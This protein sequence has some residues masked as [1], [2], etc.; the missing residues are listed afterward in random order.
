[1]HLSDIVRIDRDQF[2][3]FCKSFE[4]ASAP[5]K[6]PFRYSH[7]F[8]S[9]LNYRR[10]LR[11][12]FMRI[13]RNT[14]LLCTFGIGGEIQVPKLTPSQ[15][16]ARLAPWALED[17][18]KSGLTDEYIDACGCYDVETDPRIVAQWLVSSRY[19]GKRTEGKS[20]RKWKRRRVHVY[21]R[22]NVDDDLHNK[23]LN[24]G[25]WLKISYRDPERGYLER[26]TR[27]KPRKPWVNANGKSAKYLSAKG[28]KSRVYVPATGITRSDLEN[29]SLPLIITEGEKKADAAN[30]AG[31]V[32]IAIPGV[33]AWVKRSA[34]FPERKYILDDLAAA[35]V[36]N[37][38]VYL[39][40][41]SDLRDNLSVRH[42]LDTFADLLWGRHFADVRIVF[43]PNG[44]NGGKVG[45]DDYLTQCR[46]AGH[47]PSVS[48]NSLLSDAKCPGRHRPGRELATIG[49]CAKCFELDGPCES[50]LRRYLFP[51]W[52]GAWD[53]E[54][55]SFTNLPA[56][57]SLRCC[58]MIRKRCQH[59]E[60]RNWFR[61]LLIDCGQW[62]CENCKAKRTYNE[63]VHVERLWFLPGSYPRLDSDP[64]TPAEIHYAAV[65]DGA[66][67]KRVRNRLSKDKQNYTAIIDRFG[68]VH[69][70]SDQEFS[71]GDV[72]SRPLSPRE[73]FDDW[74]RRV[75]ALGSW[76]PGKHAIRRS[77]SWKMPEDHEKTNEWECVKDCDETQDEYDWLDHA[78]KLGGSGASSCGSGID[79][80]EKFGRLRRVHSLWNFRVPEIAVAEFLSLI[81]SPEIRPADDS[82][83]PPD[84]VRTVSPAEQFR[85][86]QPH[87]LL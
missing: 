81:V 33:W 82:G 3:A 63:C 66:D 54:S 72:S 49:R 55:E 2:N 71:I 36:A 8:S 56:V 11:R 69:L 13:P 58:K 68:S 20:R 86:Y 30:A 60:T 5:G 83:R 62:N 77:L 76:H 51:D 22:R 38:V 79:K 18:H 34:K 57:P 16:M 67:Y 48:L 53:V 15:R 78:E 52:K 65:M 39:V 12:R 80:A 44:P 29:K 84:P 28:A 32:C 35:R 47:D 31:F 25:P 9:F 45:L 74:R 50:C 17:L 14:R 27:F 24:A 21:R 42:A 1:M 87:L 23:V 26:Q 70:Y 4:A 73:A 19:L 46:A 64:P 75:V 10:A 59:K 37:R 40:F 61:M 6:V 41:D 43:L 85:N 7:I